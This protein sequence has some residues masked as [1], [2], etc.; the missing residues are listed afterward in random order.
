MF[1]FKKFRFL[2]WT[3]QA[4]IVRHKKV[5]I[6]SLLIGIIGFF[7]IY[8]I[9]PYLPQPKQKIR[10][11]KIG[12]ADLNNLPEDI[13]NKLSLGLTLVN[14]SGQAVPG[15]VDTWQLT[16]ENKTYIFQLKE[17]LYWQDNTPLTA[18]ELKL[19]F[20]DV[21]TEALDD[22]TIQFTLKEPY[23]P[24]PTILI[25]PIFKEDNL[26]VGPYRIRRV[27]KE[28]GQIKKIILSGP[29]DELIYRF[30]PTED[31]ALLGFRLAEV[32]IIDD[33]LQVDLEEEFLKQTKVDPRIASDRFIGL[34]L[35][36]EKPLLQDKA[37]RQ[38][39][40]YSIENKAEPNLRAI[41]PLSPKSW[42]YNEEIKRYD[43]D[44]QKAKELFKKDNENSNQE[45][46][47]IATTEPFLAL[48]EEVKKSW[49]EV[50]SL[51]VEIELINALPSDFDC[52]LGIQKIPP[53]PDQYLFWHSTRPE[54]ITHLKSP[55]IDKLLE[56]GR[57]IIDQGE[58]KDKYTDFQKVL[59]EESPVV[60][61]AYPKIFKLQRIK[62]FTWF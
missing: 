22:R 49:E 28:A 45:L 37:I 3:L 7:F 29:K 52:F 57:K 2:T 44:P 62:V 38:A 25:K 18:K 43:F 9:L 55:K 51:K 54:N 8:R 10:I 30:Y 42:A 19:N 17:N 5:I 32:D 13:Q 46:I 40:A 56:D 61:L 1:F 14:E 16:N 27:V 24:F 31:L 20:H 58:R 60:F 4:F 36:V 34:F 33:L 47:K 39:L 15:L 26:G 12:R 23:A 53:D 11:A 59:T 41:S 21:T 35:N 50:L 6:I 48:A